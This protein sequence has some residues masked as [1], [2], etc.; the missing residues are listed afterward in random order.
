MSPTVINLLIT[1]HGILSQVTPANVRSNDDKILKTSDFKSYFGLKQLKIKNIMVDQTRSCPK[2]GKSGMDIVIGLAETLY[3]FGEPLCHEDLLEILNYQQDIQKDI[4]AKSNTSL[5]MDYQF[6]MNENVVMMIDKFYDF[7]T[8]LEGIKPFIIYCDENIKSEI[9][10]E[11][12]SIPHERTRT[13]LSELIRI[14][15]LVCKTFGKKN[16]EINIV[17]TSC[18]GLKN[19]GNSIFTTQ[20]GFTR[21]GGKKYKKYKKIR[22]TRK[23]RK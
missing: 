21:V 19:K 16:I 15:I 17:D 23:T 2:I 8:K 1:T 9:E 20:D 10:R 18:N 5:R 7:D 13:S 11:I 22:K 14:I 4:L 6:V 3:S 12:Y